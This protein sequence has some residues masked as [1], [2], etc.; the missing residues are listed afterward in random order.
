MIREEA[1][2]KEDHAVLPQ[3]IERVT[4]T[5]PFQMLNVIAGLSMKTVGKI[6]M[7]FQGQAKGSLHILA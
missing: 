7:Q 3:T 4:V 6:V 1:M 5:A 2:G